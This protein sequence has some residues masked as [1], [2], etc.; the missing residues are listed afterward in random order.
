VKTK[1][2]G[3]QLVEGPTK[4]RSTDGRGELEAAG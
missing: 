1:G 3:E 2:A 4:P